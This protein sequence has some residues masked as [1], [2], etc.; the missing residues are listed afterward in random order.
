MQI[1]HKMKRE[2][3]KGRECEPDD[4]VEVVGEEGVP[5]RA[6]GSGSLDDDDELPLRRLHRRLLGPWLHGMA[7]RCLPPAL[8]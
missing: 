3:E 2:R 5:E 8:N 4:L 6:H 1:L 7:M